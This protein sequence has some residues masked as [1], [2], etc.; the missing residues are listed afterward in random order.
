MNHMG[1]PGPDGSVA[2]FYRILRWGESRNARYGVG[3]G[4]I[5]LTG[6]LSA[7][8]FSGRIVTVL[9]D[10]AH[11][12]RKDMRPQRRVRISGYH[13]YAAIVPVFMEAIDADG[14]AP[15]VGACRRGVP[16]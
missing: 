10:R 15:P 1:R 16:R 5:F 3:A 9:D 4:G 13:P 6:I 14:A 12:E 7:G 2:L 8:I 11:V